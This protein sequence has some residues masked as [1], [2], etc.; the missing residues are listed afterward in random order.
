MMWE[1]QGMPTH[2]RTV[3][4]KWCRYNFMKP[5][6]TMFYVIPC[7]SV[8][9]RHSEAHVYL[10]QMKSLLSVWWVY[11]RTSNPCVISPTDDGDGDAGCT[12]NTYSCS[13][14]TNFR[15]QPIM[16]STTGS[17]FANPVM[18]PVPPRNT[19]SRNVMRENNPCE[20][21]K[22][23]REKK[24]ENVITHKWNIRN[25]NTERR[26]GICTQRHGQRER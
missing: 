21:R 24:M 1:C 11:L 5:N 7:V 14:A 18:F 26:E 17:R 19:G 10:K 9:E 13:L 22:I 8:C 2:T 25:K 6:Y 3:R 16:P 4:E 20:C 12:A 15:M 23:G